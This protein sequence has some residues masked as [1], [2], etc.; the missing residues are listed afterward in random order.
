M[1]I[2][3]WIDYF[4]KKTLLVAFEN[5]AETHEYW[6]NTSKILCITR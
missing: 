2:L 5:C 6:F 1:D 4:L 3:S